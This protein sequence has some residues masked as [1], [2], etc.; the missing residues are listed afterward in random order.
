MSRGTTAATPWR[1]SVP[2]GCRRP[3]AW[4][5]GGARRRG[6]RVRRPQ[7]RVGRRGQEHELA[8]VAQREARDRRLKDRALPVRHPNDRLLGGFLEPDAYAM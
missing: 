1:R 7:Q 2:R 6:G 3:G 5:G 4:R 8:A